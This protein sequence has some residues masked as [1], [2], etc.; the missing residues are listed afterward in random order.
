ML[1]ASAIVWPK[2]TVTAFDPGCAFSA[3]PVA[4]VATKSSGPPS[5]TFF[6][7]R[8]LRVFS[9]EYSLPL[10]L[11]HEAR[12]STA[13]TRTATSLTARQCTGEPGAVHPRLAIVSRR[14]RGRRET[15]EIRAAG[16]PG[17][18]QPPAGADARHQRADRARTARARDRPPGL[19]GGRPLRR[20]PLLGSARAAGAYRRRVGRPARLLAALARPASDVVRRARRR[21]LRDHGQP[22][23]GALRRSRRRARREGTDEGGR[24]GVAQADRRAVQLDDRRLPERGL[25]ADGVRRARRRA[26]VAGGGRRGAARRG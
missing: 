18:S 6:P 9:R 26:P 25:G 16:R 24:R 13:R 14:A 4:V 8:Q 11:P 10:P 2:T 12:S 17:R 5:L 3:P 21:A 7:I 19:C 15:R 23:A 20:R 1:S 22:G